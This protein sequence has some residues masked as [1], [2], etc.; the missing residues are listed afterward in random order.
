M[1]ICNNLSPPPDPGKKKKLLIQ[2]HG[3]VEMLIPMTRE[4]NS[5]IKILFCLSLF[6]SINNNKTKNNAITNNNIKNDKIINDKYK[7]INI[8]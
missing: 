3:G 6:T 5:N 7:Y 2:S 8:I 1:L 4:Y